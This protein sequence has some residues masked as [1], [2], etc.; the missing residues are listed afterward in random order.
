MEDFISEMHP[1]FNVRVLGLA[2]DSTQTLRILGKY[3]TPMLFSGNSVIHYSMFW[4]DKTYIKTYSVDRS[5]GV[6]RRGTLDA[7][8]G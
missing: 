7:A 4:V 3:P 8:V 5:V 6:I 1:S 2:G